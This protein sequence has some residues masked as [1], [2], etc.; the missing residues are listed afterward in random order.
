MTAQLI[1]QAHE[2]RAQAAQL[3]QRAEALLHDLREIKD[4]TPAPPAQE[5]IPKK[6]GR[7]IILELR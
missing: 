6:H 1:R 7:R 5:Q 4:I 3:L 2:I